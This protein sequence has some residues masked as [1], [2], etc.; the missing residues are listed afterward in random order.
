MCD[1]AM[2]EG[3]DP[4]GPKLG[5]IRYSRNATESSGKAQPNFSLHLESGFPQPSSRVPSLCGLSFELVYE[6]WGMGAL[7]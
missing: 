7:Y 3:T 4:V 2:N 6:Q 1:K 5:T